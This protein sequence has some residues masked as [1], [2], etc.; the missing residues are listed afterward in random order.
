MHAKKKP[1]QP[2]PS[3]SGTRNYPYPSSNS[4]VSCSC[5]W[6]RWIVLKTFVWSKDTWSKFKNFSRNQ[7]INSS[8]RIFKS[9]W[10]GGKELE[11]SGCSVDISYCLLKTACKLF[12]ASSQSQSERCIV[13][14]ELLYEWTEHGGRLRRKWLKLS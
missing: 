13:S 6:W 5:F 11:N 4:V 14:A 8:I 9:Y 2:Y 7:K 3:L 12:R 1:P 10:F